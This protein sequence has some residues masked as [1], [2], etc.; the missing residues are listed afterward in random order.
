LGLGGEIRFDSDGNY[1]VVI[2]QDSSQIDI[3]YEAEGKK[4]TKDSYSKW[5]A[6]KAKAEMQG[7]GN[8]TTENTIEGT[9]NSIHYRIE[10][11]EITV[12]LDAN[13]NILYKCTING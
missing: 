8:V 13:G 5:I 7:D 4:L 12:T 3:F 6:A 11:Q 9:E 1:E 10:K 2:K